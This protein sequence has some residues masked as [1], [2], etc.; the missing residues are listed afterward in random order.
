MGRDHHQRQT[1]PQGLRGP[2]RRAGYAR[3]RIV[4]SV[5]GK[6]LAAI[7]PVRD[8]AVFERLED[9]LDVIVAER[10][11]ARVDSGEEPTYSLEEIEEP[12]RAR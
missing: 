6:E 10:I 12:T 5:H 2:P 11:L 7:V 3:E 4:I 8:L 9:I 1:G